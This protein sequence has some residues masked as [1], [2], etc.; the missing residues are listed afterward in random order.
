MKKLGVGVLVLVIVAAAAPSAL[1]QQRQR[2]QRG[3]GFGTGG[4]GAVLRRAQPSTFC[5][6]ARPFTRSP[7][8]PAAAARVGW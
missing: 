4:A 2:G 5:R 7:D 6:D 3:A 1:A 8:P